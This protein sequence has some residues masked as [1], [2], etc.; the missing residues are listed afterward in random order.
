MAAWVVIGAGY[1]GERVVAMLRGRG[2]EV[3]VT[4]R[5]AGE[6]VVG[7]ELASASVEEIAAVIGRAGEDAV[8]VVAA[9]PVDAIGGAEGKLAMAAAAARARR[10]VYVSSTG[11]YA[12]AAGAWVDE[13][14]AIAPIA[15]SGRTRL[16]AEQAIAGGGV[17]CVILRAAGIYGPGRGAVERLRTGAYRII[18]GGDT[19]VSRVHADDLAAA[20]VLAGDA[21]APGSVYNVADD[22]PCTSNELAEAA[23]AA[24][25]LPPPPRVALD[26]VDAELA[27]MF[28]ADRRIDN[29]RL[30]RE[31]GWE[32]RF[33][34]WRTALGAAL[35]WC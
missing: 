8:V 34:S 7:L 16:A 14:F 9:P 6:G 22:D 28:S 15:A 27:A 23:C 18:G 29:R 31:L 2:D 33:P 32:P 3:I 21:R 26:A 13:A 30:R 19:H 17:P 12:A 10:I 24:L 20:V 25:A 4:R 35:A 11:V 1:T 5:Q